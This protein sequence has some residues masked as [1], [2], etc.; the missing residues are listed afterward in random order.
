MLSF[1]TVEQVDSCL[2]THYLSFVFSCLADA[3][4]KMLSSSKICDVSCAL[5]L[6]CGVWVHFS[7]EFT[8]LAI[9]T[10]IARMTR[11]SSS[12]PTWRSNSYFVRYFVRREPQAFNSGPSLDVAHIAMT[13]I[14]QSV[15]TRTDLIVSKFALDSQYVEDIRRRSSDRPSRCPK[16]GRPLRSNRLSFLLSEINPSWVCTKACTSQISRL[17]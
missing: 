2:L 4:A 15:I 12:L 7:G 13:E 16:E 1:P 5:P 11:K 14:D 8:Q 9:V 3:I 6:R 17:Y 10:S